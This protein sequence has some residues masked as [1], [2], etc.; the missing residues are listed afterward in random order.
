VATI[1]VY[2][3]KGGV[4]KT[5]LAVNLAWASA[6]ISK[7]R[8]LL[9]DL[10]AQASASFILAP[11]RKARDEARA[12]LERDIPAG[13][14]IIGTDIPQLD[15]M[16]ADSSLRGLD[17]VFM[18]IGRKKRILRLTEDLQGLYDH[19]ILDCPPGLGP[20]TAQIIRSA[21]LIL[22]PMIPSTLSRRAYTEVLTYLTVEHKG[23]PPI[24]PVFN[25][26]DRRRRAHRK[27][28]ADDPGCPAVPMASV[29]EQ[30]A[31][32]HAPLGVYAP[33]S[34]AG[35]AVTKL[36]TSIERRLASA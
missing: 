23:G 19:I 18:E 4:G 33:R 8:T 22:L 31:D 12:V 1:A 27:A 11:E 5:T 6:A 26:V 34:P 30:M 35:V 15:L 9:W 21:T 14:I 25:M 28:M 17:T 32:R 3:M 2:N 29:V 24:F 36:W 20:T 10:D 13:D 7:R 16:P